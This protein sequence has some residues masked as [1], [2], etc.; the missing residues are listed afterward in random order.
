MGSQFDDDFADA[1]LPDFFAEFGR[2]V[3]FL[4]ATGQSRQITMCLAEDGRDHE[5]KELVEEK[6]E[7]LWVKVHRDPSNAAYGGI[8]SP[9]QGDSL[10]HPDETG[11]DPTPFSYQGEIRNPDP[12]A[13]EL[14][15]A[16]NRPIGYRGRA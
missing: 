11:D 10:L 2:V 9:R 5:E 3:T 14:L 7:R 4:P 8:A 13:W 1:A 16:R 12:Y 15:F 6:Q